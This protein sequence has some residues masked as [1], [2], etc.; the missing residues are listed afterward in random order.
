MAIQVVEL[1]KRSRDW[2]AERD[3]PSPRLD[4]EL[5]LGHVLGLDRLRLYTAFDRPVDP[6][7]LERMRGLIRRRAAGEPI[8]YIVGHKEFY[9][10]D[11]AVDARVLIPRPDTELLVERAL[12]AL[13]AEGLVL[14]YGVG[15]GAIGL[16]LLAERPALKLLA[17]DVSRDALE[18]AKQN[19]AAL[20]VADRAGFVHSDGF[21]RVPERFRGGFAGIV[22]NPPYIPDADRDGLPRDVRD[23][24]PPGALFAG[25]GLEHYR[26]IAAEAR[27]WLQPGGWLGLEVGQGQSDAVAALLAG[28]PELVV[29]P[30]LAGIPRVVEACRG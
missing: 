30:D 22:A 21:A 11:F 20:G 13:P 25:D 15:S 8:A 4:A 14:D 18:V 27:A 7:E 1:L 26:R 17:V 2:L 29:T 24:E 19:A 23:F 10:R 12:A 9:G 6:P 3:V 28:W 5:L 16:T